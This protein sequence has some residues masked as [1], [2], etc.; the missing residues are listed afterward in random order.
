MVE[1]GIVQVELRIHGVSGTPA[2]TMLGEAVVADSRFHGEPGTV[3]RPESG[4]GSLLA[5]RWASQTS[6]TRRSALWL[7][8]VPYMLVNVAGWALPP[9]TEVRHRAAVASTR[10]AGLF[11]TLVFALVTA[12]GVIGVGAYQVVREWTS[13]GVALVLGLIVAGVLMGVLWFAAAR[14]DDARNDRPYLR[15]SHIAVALW[16]VWAAGTTAAGEVSAHG[17]PLG[18]TWLLP[19]ALAILVAAGS[20]W[21]DLEGLTRLMGRI[22][23]V[24]VVVLLVALAASD[25]TPVGDLPDALTV[26]GGPLRGGVIAYLA[27]ALVTTV[28]AWSTEHPDAG[29]AVG[30]LL[31]IAGATGAAVG[32]GAVVASGA[33]FGATPSR[34]TAGLAGAFLAGALAVGA[35]AA[36]HAIAHLEPG[37]S[38]LERVAKTAV[39]LREDLRPLLVVIPAVTVVLAVVALAGGA[40][41]MGWLALGAALAAATAVGELL[42]RLSLRG[43]SV[44]PIVVVAGAT[45]LVAF[46]VVTFTALAVTFALL[47]PFGAV[48]VR[49]VGARSDPE[50]RR[51]LAIPWDVGSFFARR[52]HP[53]GPPTYRDIVERDL[54]TVLSQLRG[55]GDGLV[56]S[57]HSQ[58]SIVA[59]AALAGIPGRGISL[60]TYGSPLGSL[61][62]RF[63]PVSF[64]PDVVAAVGERP[65]INL[66]RPTDPIG[67]A[68]LGPLT[69]R[70][71]EDT[72]LRLHGGY[73]LGDEPE[74]ARA[75]ADLRR[76]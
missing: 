29:P 14:A 47:V 63:F 15:S 60:L 43:A 39:S 23:V 33:I 68:V 69:D 73:W 62:M 22:A 34:S 67:G 66:W 49:V 8:L 64:P 13:W 51:V 16:G 41:V 74:F 24:V 26:L 71:I 65:W 17:N 76:E 2:E 50:R 59:A 38:L 10:V 9:A 7:L 57:A 19:A 72:H 70:R 27:A 37:A 30:T 6:G 4:D 12:N 48:T 21:H 25:Q 36:A 1:S 54:K 3:L 58:G 56:V 52:F 18:S 5:Y 20:V 55:S 40:P 11:L 46:D 35:A 28:L 45:A 31:A 61:Y 44:V 75:L 42:R 53:F 32:A